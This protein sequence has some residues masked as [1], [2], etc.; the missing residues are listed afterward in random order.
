MIWIP[1]IIVDAIFKSFLCSWPILVPFLLIIMFLIINKK[2]LK[3]EVGCDNS[4]LIMLSNSIKALVIILVLMIVTNRVW[5]PYLYKYILSLSLSNKQVEI[6][7]KLEKKYNRN[8]TFV[9]KD[10]LNVYDYDGFLEKPRFSTIYRFKDDD[11]VIAIVDYGKKSGY[12]YYESKRSKYEIEQ[13]VYNYARKVNFDAEF[14]VFVDSPY[15]LI[16][17]SSLNKK[18]SDDFVNDFILEKRE[19][20]SIQFISYTIS[21]K[22]QKFI[23]SFLKSNYNNNIDYSIVDYEVRIDDYKK[24]VNY[25]ESDKIKNGIEGKDYELYQFDEELTYRRHYSL[26]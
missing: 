22:K 13:S 10:E 1:Y 23:L 17:Y 12:D 7:E 8:F 2:K 21:D 15:Q 6:E 11:G 14:Y 24:I 5:G 18:V 3:K 26:N 9:S 16:D 4:K 19:S 20:V 25:Y